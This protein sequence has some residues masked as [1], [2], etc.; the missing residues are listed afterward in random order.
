MGCHTEGHFFTISFT[1]CALENAEM[2]VAVPPA[3]RCGLP[4]ATT[5]GCE[6]LQ[7]SPVNQQ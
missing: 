1:G 2:E 6:K 4:S 7:G 5:G 3:E